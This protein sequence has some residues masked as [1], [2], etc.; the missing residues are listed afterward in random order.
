MADVFIS[1][2]TIDTDR[3]RVIHDSLK[4]HGLSVFWSN[5]IAK[6]ASNYQSII[7]VEIIKAPAVLAVWTHASVDS[8]PVA[9][10]CAQAR[11]D[12]KLF[13]VVLDDI[14]P[15]H[16]PME[17]GFKSQKTMLEGWSGDLR[18]AEWIA[19]VSAIKARLAGRADFNGMWSGQWGTMELEQTDADV[20]GAYIYQS[21]DGPQYGHID[22][23]VSDRVLQFRW[24]QG[25]ERT[26][27]YDSARH[28]GEGYF[29]LSNDGLRL[30]GRW[31]MMGATSWTGDW[32]LSRGSS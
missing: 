25:L 1:L 6:G 10:E 18:N 5:D 23:Q 22:G 2:C 15:I 3:V 31:R 20:T 9:Q 27:T 26:L 7:K 19:L 14:E 11:L 30:D 13:Q 12:K 29:I 32:S 21:T 4:A 24:W 28:K 16:F 8:E 17:A